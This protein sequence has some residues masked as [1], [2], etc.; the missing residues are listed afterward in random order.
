MNK[1][2]GYCL[3]MT[4]NKRY[5]FNHPLIAYGYPKLPL[6]IYKKTAY[7]KIMAVTKRANHH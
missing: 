5:R 1:N 4:V 2:S 6:F 3:P 7:T